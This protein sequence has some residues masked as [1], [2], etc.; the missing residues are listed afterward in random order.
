MPRQGANLDGR[1][2]SKQFR[3]MSLLKQTK[4]YWNCALIFHS[5]ARS[6]FLCRHG[7]RKA[8]L[9]NFFVPRSEIENKPEAFMNTVIKCAGS[10]IVQIIHVD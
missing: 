3:L 7:E 2:N 5:P 6:G 4:S 1:N 8:E 10:G 9:M